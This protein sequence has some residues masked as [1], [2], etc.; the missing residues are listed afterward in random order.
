MPTELDDFLKTK[1]ADLLTYLRILEA[2]FAFKTMKTKCFCEL[3]VQ[4]IMTMR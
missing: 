1:I 3:N 4:N 2:L